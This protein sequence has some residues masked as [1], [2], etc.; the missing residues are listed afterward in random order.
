MEDRDRVTRKKMKPCSL[1]AVEEPDPNLDR[2]FSELSSLLDN[3]IE[4]LEKNLNDSAAITQEIDQVMSLFQDRSQP[5]SDMTDFELEELLDF[6]AM[7]DVIL[8]TSLRL[9]VLIA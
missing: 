6:E 7:E 5:T 9:L 1:Q 8:S 3:E 4:V 2:S